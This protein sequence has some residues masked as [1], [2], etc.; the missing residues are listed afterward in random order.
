MR[1]PIPHMVFL[2]LNLSH[3][4]ILQKEQEM[5]NTREQKVRLIVS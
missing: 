3:E 4:K 5:A 1:R 2:S